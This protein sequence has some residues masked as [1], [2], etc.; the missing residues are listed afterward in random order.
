MDRPNVLVIVLDTARADALE[1]YGAAPGTTPALAQL[2]SSGKAL[3][4]VHSTACWTMPS[5]ASMFTGLLPR[6]AG[7]NRAPGER[8]SGCKP[9]LEGAVDRMLPEVLR[10]AGFRTRGVSSNLWVARASGFATGFD[11]WRDVSPN[12]AAQM[13]ST[14]WRP[15]A[16]W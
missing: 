12:R 16:R 4:D 14:K 1:P 15:R 13:V 5:H 6:A 9:V 10:R 8:P 2:A 11:E 7:L 3:P